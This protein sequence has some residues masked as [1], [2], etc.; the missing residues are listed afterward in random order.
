MSLLREK[1]LELGLTMTAVAAS[2]GIDLGRLSRLER[3]QARLTDKELVKLA[4]AMK[5]SPLDLLPAVA[6]TQ[7]EAVHV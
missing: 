6:P 5:C 1:R 3:D 2:A 7:E 4:A